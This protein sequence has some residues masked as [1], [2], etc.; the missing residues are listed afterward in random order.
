VQLFHVIIHKL[1][2]VLNR[3][4]KFIQGA[5]HKYFFVI[6][7]RL[8]VLVVKVIKKQACSDKAEQAIRPSCPSVIPPISEGTPEDKKF[9]SYPEIT[10][11]VFSFQQAGELL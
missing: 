9:N 2:V 8:Y 7:P 11:Q 10:A 5:N 6:P 4:G 3:P 1:P